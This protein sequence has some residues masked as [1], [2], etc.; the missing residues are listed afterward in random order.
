MMGPCNRLHGRRK[1]NAH[2]QNGQL[3]GRIMLIDEAL[4]AYLRNRDLSQYC[5]PRCLALEVKANMMEGSPPGPLMRQ[6]KMFEDLSIKNRDIKQDVA[7]ELLRGMEGSNIASYLP[8]CYCRDV[9]PIDFSLEDGIFCSH[10]NCQIMLFHKTCLE[11][12]GIL[13]V[14]QVSH[15]YCTECH[16]KMQLLAYKALGESGFDNVRGDATAPS[17]ARVPTPCTTS[18][19]K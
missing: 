8:M 11:D 14:D 12:L 7:L 17:I 4:I 9:I 3:K 15:W 16:D 19:C 10:R 1:L 2:F 5:V 6:V 18:I 13:D